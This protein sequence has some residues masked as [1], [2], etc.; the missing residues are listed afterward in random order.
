MAGHSGTPLVAATAALLL[1]SGS[2]GAQT[3]KPSRALSPADVDRVME[4]A[5]GAARTVPVAA[6]DDA[7]WLRRVMLDL[8]GRVPTLAEAE[9]FLAERA[10]DR[11][12]RLVDRLLASADYAEHWADVFFDLFVGR[13]F[14]KPRVKREL[15]PR[16]YFVAA[17]RGGVAYDRMAFEMITFTGE[18]LP[19]GPG[20][21][22]AS[23]LKGGGPEAIANATAKLFLGL[24]ISCAQCHDHPTDR[25]YKQEDF[26]G[27]A[28]YFART[29]YKQMKARADTGVEVMVPG[30][31]LADP[32]RRYFVVDKPAG[33][34]KFK[35]AGS[36][37]DVVAAPKFL[38][39]TPATAGSLRETVARAV[40]TSDL[41][42]KA[43]IDRV[44]SRLFG[45]GLVEPWEDLGGED[46]PRHPPLL[47]ALADD[48][49]AGGHDLRRLLRLLV[50][51]RAYGLTSRGPESV[52]ADTFARAAVR[53]LSPEQLFRSLHVVTGM[54]VDE[55]KM[56]R[57]LREYVYVFGDDEGA[58]VDALAGNVPQAL[59]MWN[60]EVTNLGARSRA[61]GTLAGILAASVDPAVRLRRM[62]LA[63]YARPPSPAEAA[64]LT[65][66]LRSVADHEDVFFALLTS[67]EMA[68][69]H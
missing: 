33:E 46:D 22:L 23:H 3:P 40:V 21:F 24:Q 10:P 12:A 52:P 69:N 68:S 59:L 45:R 53:R 15:D 19:N 36:T 58:T 43:A 1:L 4:A 49:R 51:T 29:R 5:W 20:V 48:F 7:E 35:R 32:G 47:R 11:R 54:T 34:A 9:G 31:A 38:G 64:R 37:D 16:A 62:F 8:V 30:T 60:G 2:A 18:I 63:A 66:R 25:R 26:Y 57:L 41:F 61:G 55:N 6:A 56:D 44:W 13:Q 50:A 39:R 17:L 27:F 65:P 14:R 28:A 67:S 42:A